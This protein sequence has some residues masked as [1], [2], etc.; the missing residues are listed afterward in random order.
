VKNEIH[1]R[2]KRLANSYT[3]ASKDL[4][5][6]LLEVDK[7]RAFEEKEHT[8]LTPY[9]IKFLNIDPDVTKT[10]V[11]IV[12]KSID[13][14]ELAQAVIDGKIHV[15]NAKV[16]SSVITPENKEEWI[17]KAAKL[18]KAKLE[19]EISK[20]GGPDK[21]RVALDLPLETFE[22]L[23]RA[24]DLVSTKTSKFESFETTLETALEEYIHRHDPIE[25]ANRSK[26]PQGHPSKTAVRHETNLKD[27][28]RCGWIFEDGTQC[29]ERK[30]LQQHHIIAKAD[31]GQDTVE[32]MI[33]LCAAHHRMHHKLH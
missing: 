29:E 8:H 21:K 20:S 23:E 24:R 32:N 28:A 4:I 1:A 22:M 33:C 13:V 31:G 9:C 19:K 14:P 27:D 16:I 6:V 30:W 5:S 11:R 7:T 15:S 25:K 2:A 3:Q 17:E 10:L 12:R 18:P 26:C